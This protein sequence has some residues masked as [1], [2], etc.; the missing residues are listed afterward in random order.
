MSNITPNCWVIATSTSLS[1]GKHEQVFH[2]Y[3]HTYMTETVSVI[4][5][6]RSPPLGEKV[7]GGDLFAAPITMICEW[8]A[9]L[10][11][12]STYVYMITSRW[13]ECCSDLSCSRLHNMNAI[14]HTVL[15][16]LPWGELW[17]P[18]DPSCRSRDCS[19]PGASPSPPPS[20]LE[21]NKRRRQDIVV[22]HVCACA[23]IL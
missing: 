13:S 12:G 8:S 11:C 2:T 22:W 6:P 16:P 19:S 1:G 14:Y 9:A 15:S 3:I 21:T 5:A 7:T 10:H 23:T 4:C 20:V 18:R 17:T